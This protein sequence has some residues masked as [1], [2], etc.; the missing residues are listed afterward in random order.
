MTAA[1]TMKTAPSEPELREPSTRVGCVVVGAAV[2]VAVD[3]AGETVG[4]GVGE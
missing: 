3:G 2:G 4:T 1:T